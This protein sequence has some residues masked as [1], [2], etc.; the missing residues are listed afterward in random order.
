[1]RI[2]FPIAQIACRIS[3]STHFIYP[4]LPS[5]LEPVLWNLPYLNL[6]RL[7]IIDITDNS[8]LKWL[9]LN[10]ESQFSHLE[11]ESY[12]HKQYKTRSQEARVDATRL[13]FKRS[14]L[15][16]SQRFIKILDG[17]TRASAQSDSSVHSSHPLC[18]GLLSVRGTGMGDGY[19]MKFMIFVSKLRLDAT[20]KT[21]AIDAA[22]S[23]EDNL[24][25]STL[26]FY[27]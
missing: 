9:V 24:F 19:G 16:M 26:S 4:V 14:L 7:P 25:H 8:D 27:D 20:N 6:E 5:K 18:H 11:Y 3:P 22:V 23:P 13:E 1:M 12:Q 21:I 10:T 2:T 17:S 15:S